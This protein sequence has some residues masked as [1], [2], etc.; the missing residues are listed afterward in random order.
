[1]HFFRQALEAVYKSTLMQTKYGLQQGAKMEV[2]NSKPYM[3]PSRVSKQ[4][5]FFTTALARV[6]FEQKK[7]IT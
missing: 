7:H 1:M 4:G 6:H 3:Q 5:E 2:S